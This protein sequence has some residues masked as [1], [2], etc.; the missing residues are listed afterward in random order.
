MAFELLEMP[1][2]RRLSEP[3]SSVPPICFPFLSGFPRKE[4]AP[5]LV[6]P[7]GSQNKG[8]T[9]QDKR[10]VEKRTWLRNAHVAVC[11]SLGGTVLQEAERKPT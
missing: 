8:T 1:R 4:M 2:G 9:L 3:S 7:F 5:I 6:L 11:K 10:R